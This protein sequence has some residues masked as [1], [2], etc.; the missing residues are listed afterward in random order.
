MADLR[1]KTIRTLIIND[2][3]DELFWHINR[4]NNATMGY[5]G[6]DAHIIRLALPK[7]FTENLPKHLRAE[8]KL[9]LRTVRRS[10]AHYLEIHPKTLSDMWDKVD[11][12][13]TFEEFMQALNNGE[14]YHYVLG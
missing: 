11:E 6:D 1:I 8:W 12:R 13:K 2:V 9:I 5:H 10:K 7:G 14:L 3:T 4:S